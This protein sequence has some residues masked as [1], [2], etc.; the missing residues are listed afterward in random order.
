MVV[1]LLKIAC[2][3]YILIMALSCAIWVVTHIKEV[4]LIVMPENK[5][6]GIKKG[7]GSMYVGM[8][9]G[10]D[11]FVTYITYSDGKTIQFRDG[12]W[13]YRDSQHVRDQEI[14][15]YLDTKGLATGILV[16]GPKVINTLHNDFI[17]ISRD[18][19][20]ATMIGALIC[21]SMM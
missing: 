9:H 2:Y 16:M 18:V 13:V 6:M 21:I 10:T 3:L 12:G 17:K 15:M 7:V 5:V 11:Y 14:Y 20:L 19:S 1:E 4:L 8:P